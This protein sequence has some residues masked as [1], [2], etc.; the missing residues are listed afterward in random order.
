MEEGRLALRA[1][2]HD[3]SG[4]GDGRPIVAHGVVVAG[5]R[6]G[7]AVA[8]LVPVREG[9]YTLGLERRTLLAASGLDERAV[10]VALPAVGGHAAFPPER[11]RYAWM[12]ACR[13]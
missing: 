4:D 12:N 5:Q 3:A 2:G 11:L 1:H 9:R 10:V 13:P 7:G 6:L 8:P